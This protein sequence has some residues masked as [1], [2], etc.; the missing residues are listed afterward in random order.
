MTYYI[1]A[2]YEHRQDSYLT[3]K[4]LP[5]SAVKVSKTLHGTLNRYTAIPFYSL[6][7][8]L[9][10]RIRLLFLRR[11]ITNHTILNAVFKNVV[12]YFFYPHSRNEFGML[13]AGGLANLTRHITVDDLSLFIKHLSASLSE[14]GTV[15]FEMSIK[16]EAEAT[17]N[18]DWVVYARR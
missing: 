13:S 4:D 14:S 5:S 9:W 12:N 6:V 7:D 15:P 10:N 8:W 16:Q 3:I 18:S 17:Y 1:K 2:T 11:A